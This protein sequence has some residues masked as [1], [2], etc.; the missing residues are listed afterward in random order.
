MNFVKVS[1]ENGDEFCSLTSKVLTYLINIDQA[2]KCY[3]QSSCPIDEAKCFMKIILYSNADKNEKT[4][5][6]L[7]ADFANYI[8]NDIFSKFRG[9]YRYSQQKHADIILLARD[10]KAYGYFVISEMVPP[11]SEDKA[12]AKN[13][14]KVY[15]VKESVAFENRVPLRDLNIVGYQ[16]GKAITEEQFDNIKQLGGRQYSQTNDE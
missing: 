14:K 12:L 10:A 2:N 7:E 9:R 11:N 15:I 16:F 13:P 1:D 3:T 8:R 5:F 4:G 6:P